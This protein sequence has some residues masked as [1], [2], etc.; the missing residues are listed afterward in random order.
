MNAARAGSMLAPA[1]PAMSDEPLPAEAAETP[2]RQKV[3]FPCSNCGAKL[4]WDPES[5]SLAC[6][7]CGTRMAV[8][9]GEGTIVERALED[10]GAA[11]R[12]LGVELRA[13]RCANCG[14]S[15]CLSTSSTAERC[16]YC[17]SSS[18]L[19]QDANRN[20]LRPESLVP[21]DLSR[22]QVEERFRKWLHGLWFR[23]GELKRSKAFD[24]A[25]IYVPYWTFDCRVHSEWSADAGHYYYVTV[26]RVV[27]V[28]GRTRT[29][30]VRERRIRWVPAFGK[31]DDAYDDELVCASGLAPEL[32][33]K[34]GGFDTRALVPYRP[35]YLAGWRAEEY[36]LDLEQ[37]WTRAQ[38]AVE[39]SQRSRCAG[40]VPGDTHRNLRV[41]NAISGV[42]WKHVLLPV[43]SLQYRF[44]SETYTVLVNGQTGCVAGK[45]PISWAKVALLV[46]AVLGVGLVA[47]GVLALTGALR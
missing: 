37:G 8:P 35:E 12:G 30:M 6:E 45:A 19:A 46:A 38:A 22:T 5:D 17:G 32:V 25:G 2:T 43:W 31:R 18:V 44:K 21:L 20:A 10:A 13:V 7:Y 27:R 36:R 11:A 47:L 41:R 34:L 3:D 4:T 23:P 39:D 9:R 26:P 14:A 33:R 40:D 24:A 15:V 28:G 16:V 29:Q 1:L 42:R